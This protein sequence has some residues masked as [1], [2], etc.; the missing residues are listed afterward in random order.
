MN[1]RFFVFPIYKRPIFPGMTIPI[2]VE[3]FQYDI[4]KKIAKNND[5][6]NRYLAVFLSKQ[7]SFDGKKV[8]IHKVGVL[9]KIVKIIP[10]EKNT[11]VFLQG[12]ERITLK[13]ITATEPMMAEVVRHTEPLIVAPAEQLQALR[14]NIISTIKALVT[15]NSVFK[16]ELQ[17]FL[18]HSDFTDLSKLADFAVNFTTISKEEL[19]EILETFDIEEKLHKTLS[20]LKKELRIAELQS[21]INSDIECNISKTH[22][23]ILLKEQ[24]K[25]IQKELGSKSG[26]NFDIAKYE[27]ICTQKKIPQHAQNIIDEELNKL[28]NLELSSPEYSLC[29]NY[30]EWLTNMPWGIYSKDLTSLRRATRVLNEDHYGLQDVK[31][32]HY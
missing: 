9:A 13:K 3:A 16:D 27:K 24:L 29:A 28:R 12:E 19:Q 20:L 14:N 17:I 1:N 4:L 18:T 22:R 6:Q 21:N 26:K 5:G 32:T 7:D 11:Q 15:L 10:A 25:V 2:I 8:D 30:L 23:N 31:K